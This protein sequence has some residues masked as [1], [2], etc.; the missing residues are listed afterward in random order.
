[1]ATRITGQLVER[2]S[3]KTNRAYKVFECK[4]TLDNGYEFDTLVFPS[5]EDN[6]VIKALNSVK[7]G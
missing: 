4:I 1:M 3:A 2:I 6:A 5:N 7:G